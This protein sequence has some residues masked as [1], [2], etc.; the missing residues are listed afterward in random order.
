[1]VQLAFLPLVVCVQWHDMAPVLA[2]DTV[3]THDFARH[4]Q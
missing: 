1:M 2:L 4:E 3:H